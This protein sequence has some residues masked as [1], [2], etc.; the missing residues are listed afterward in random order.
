M[1]FRRYM[2]R[3]TKGTACHDV[4]VK[5]DTP[6]SEIFC[7]IPVPTAFSE[8][9]IFSFSPNVA[10]QIHFFLHVTNGLFK[11]YCEPPAMEKKICVLEI[12]YRSKPPY[13]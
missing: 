3:T 13:L 9:E 8:M 12:T 11:F 4:N 10:S 2:V 1:R 7:L 5:L 6:P